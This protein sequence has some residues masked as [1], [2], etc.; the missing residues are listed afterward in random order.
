MTKIAIILGSTRPGRNGD[1]VANWVLQQASTR[2]DAEFELVDLRDHPLPHLDEELPASMGMYSHHH[3]KKWAATIAAY[4]GFVFVTPEYNHGTTGVLKNAIDYLYAEWNNKAAGFVSYGSAGG[5]RA[6]EHLRLI[7]GELQVADV[8]Q[9][10]QFSLFH[11][12]ENFSTFV[13]GPQHE[14]SVALMFDQVVSWSE[15]LRT[16]RDAAGRQATAA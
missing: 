14:A 7:M 4:D 12:F 6:V 2:T 15:A 8:R 9:Q 13:P 11:D 10:V 16:V 1:A 5:A 3:T